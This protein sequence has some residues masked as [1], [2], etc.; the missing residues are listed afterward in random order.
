M[1]INIAFTM[2]TIKYRVCE[3]AEQPNT[4]TRHRFFAKS[5]WT[6]APLDLR[7]KPFKTEIMQNF[8]ATITQPAA[9]FTKN[10]VAKMICTQNARVGTPKQNF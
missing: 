6:K 9:L 3:G 4:G 5:K 10:E 2:N 8:Q 7:T 1:R